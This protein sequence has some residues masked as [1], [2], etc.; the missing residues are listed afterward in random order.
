MRKFLIIAAAVAVGGCASNSGI[1]PDGTDAYRISVVGGSGFTSS[2]SLKAKSYKQ[3]TDF[4]AQKGL[5]VETIANDT[6]QA[7][8]LGGFPE[9]DLRF[10]CVK[11]EI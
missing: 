1:V 4:C 8:P 6:K 7:R 3:A 2:G 11:R 9:S 5:T 10:R